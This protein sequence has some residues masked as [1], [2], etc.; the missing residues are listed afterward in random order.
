MILQVC[1]P[2]VVFW[3]GEYFSNYAVIWEQCVKDSL[4]SQMLENV[5]HQ[6][7]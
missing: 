5:E 7:A 4:R 2:A 3:P 1:Y 6:F